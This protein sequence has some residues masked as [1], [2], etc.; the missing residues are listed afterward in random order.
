MQIGTM[1][2]PQRDVIEEIR[3]MADM[4]ME[5]VDL[6]LEPPAAASWRVDPRA[7]RS[8]LED[9]GL[10]VVGHTCYYLP[11]AS[12]FEEIRQG[13]ITEFKR[14]LDVFCEIGARWMNV[15]PDRYIPMHDRSYWIER[16]LESLQ[17]LLPHARACGIG[18]MIENLPGPFNTPEQLG[19]LLDPLPE[20]GLHMDIGH[21]NL[22]TVQ[23]TAPALC[24]AYG[25]R[26]AHV[27]IH[28]NKGGRADLHLPLGAGTMD[29]GPLIR[30]LKDARYDGTIA[31]EVF[32]PDKEFLRYSVEVL[33]RLWAE[34]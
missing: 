3:W 34:G 28:D 22:Q 1:N 5:F 8:A 12:P 30:A 31:L 10:G 27:H 2:H 20:L 6:T 26:L 21:C 14:C 13:A 32:T 33:R 11:L 19:E 7:I 25:D 17:E 29:L 9:H 18:L 23:N 15:H 4:G 16:N 24:A